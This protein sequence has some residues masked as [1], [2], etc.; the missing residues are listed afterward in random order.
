MLY[1]CLGSAVVREFV[2]YS[3]GS[4]IKAEGAPVNT[5]VA[6]PTEE[7]PSFSYSRDA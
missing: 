7:M 1:W 5:A 6:S 2:F 3:G 4:G